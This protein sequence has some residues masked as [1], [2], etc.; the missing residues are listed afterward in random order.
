MCAHDQP[1]TFHSNSKQVARITTLMKKFTIW[2]SSWLLWL[3]S[4]SAWRSSTSRTKSI[5]RSGNTSSTFKFW[6]GNALIWRQKV[7]LE[8]SEGENFIFHPFFC[9]MPFQPRYE[10]QVER[11]LKVTFSFNSMLE[12][13]KTNRIATVFVTQIIIFPWML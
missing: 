8:M 11:R 4:W 13:D 9:L 2:V 7:I 1:T 6:D 3:P 5:T 10:N 12:E